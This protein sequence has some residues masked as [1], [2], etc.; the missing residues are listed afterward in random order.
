MFG[1][2]YPNADINQS[3][4]ANES[5]YFVVLNTVIGVIF[6][7]FR[8]GNGEDGALLETFAPERRQCSICH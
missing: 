3:E 8:V 6:V 1:Y 2:S 7:I 4:L 5:R